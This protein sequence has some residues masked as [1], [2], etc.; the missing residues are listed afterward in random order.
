[1]GDGDFGGPAFDHGITLGTDRERRIVTDSFG[2]SLN[3]T[4]QNGLL[5]LRMLP[6][7][8]LPHDRKQLSLGPDLAAPV[9]DLFLR[10]AGGD[11][12]L[13]LRGE[14]QNFRG[15]RAE[16]SGDESS[17]DR[18]QIQN[19]PAFPMREKTRTLHA[20]TRA[21]PPAKMMRLRWLRRSPCA[22]TCRR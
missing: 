12:M 3:F 14:R 11:V 7:P 9:D 18:I 17:H 2:R 4:Y 6:D 10:V 1:M 20:I 5:Q 16:I 21:T 15:A 13:V 19:H 8:S 22:M